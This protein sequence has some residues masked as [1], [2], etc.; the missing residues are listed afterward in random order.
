MF[1]FEIVSLFGAIISRYQ[2]CAHIFII[3]ATQSLLIFWPRHTRCCALHHDGSL[4]C[5]KFI[6]MCT[7]LVGFAT[8][9]FMFAQLGGDCH[10]ASN[11]LG[12]VETFA[13]CLLAFYWNLQPRVESKWK[14]NRICGD[15]INWLP[16]NG[17]SQIVIKKLLKKDG[18]KI[19]QKAAAVM[20]KS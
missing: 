10:C 9:L 2:R 17:V 8:Q 12:V 15:I 6:K 1:T 19:Q 3:D 16:D 5:S 20:K 4:H 18:A 11:V 14:C 13:K 7:N